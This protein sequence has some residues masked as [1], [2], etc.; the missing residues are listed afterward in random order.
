MIALRAPLARSAVMLALAALGGCAVLPEP[1]QRIFSLPP[2]EAPVEA[3]GDL[4]RWWARFD[5]AALSADIERAIAHNRRLAAAPGEVREC[6]LELD[7]HQGSKRR[8]G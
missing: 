7:E 1:V 5:D 6:D 4:E 8:T 2:Q 3:W